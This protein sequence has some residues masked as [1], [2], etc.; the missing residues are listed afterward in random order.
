M[1]STPKKGKKEKAPEDKM[2]DSIKVAFKLLTYFLNP[3]LCA[4]LD[5]TFPMPAT[6][7]P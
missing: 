6:F 5:P 7:E 4:C 3:L 2:E 1:S